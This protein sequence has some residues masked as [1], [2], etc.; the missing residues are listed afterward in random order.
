MSLICI[1]KVTS[2]TAKTRQDRKADQNFSH[3]GIRINNFS[4]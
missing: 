4:D 2:L 3:K 1:K